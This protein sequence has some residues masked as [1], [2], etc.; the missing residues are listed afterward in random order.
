MQKTLY[1]EPVASGNLFYPILAK[2]IPPLWYASTYPINLLVGNI[3]IVAISHDN[4]N[5]H[6]GTSPCHLYN[7]TWVFAL[8]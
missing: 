2:A 3:L 7:L 5:W 6:P 1:R 4:I 8:L